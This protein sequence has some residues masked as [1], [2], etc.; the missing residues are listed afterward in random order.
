[1]DDIIIQINVPQPSMFSTRARQDCHTIM[2][3]KVDAVTGQNC[4]HI[5]LIDDS[6]DTKQGTLQVIEHFSRK[7]NAWQT[8]EAQRAGGLRFDDATLR[9]L[10]MCGVGG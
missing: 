8:F 1:M 6:T 2:V 10:Y 4:L 9:G 5:G 3:N 7:G